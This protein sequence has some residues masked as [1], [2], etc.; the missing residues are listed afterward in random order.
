MLRRLPFLRVLDFSRS[1]NTMEQL[2]ACGR[3]YGLLIDQCDS[4]VELST[5]IGQ[6]VVEYAQEASVRF[7]VK[8]SVN[9][10]TAWD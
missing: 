8:F 2:A 4:I 3:Q 1:V 7:D 9:A 10:L 5:L 6:K